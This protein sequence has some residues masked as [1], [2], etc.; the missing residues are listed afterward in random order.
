MNS[1]KHILVTVLISAVLSSCSGTFPDKKDCTPVGIFDE[2]WNTVNER[3]VCF[4]NKDIDW[5]AAYDEYRGRITGETDD[6]QLFSTLC[7]M[8]GE[9]KDGH[10]SL[11]DG[12]RTWS[13]HRPDSVGN[14]SHYVVF[15]YLGGAG[16]RMAGGLY[17]NKIKNGKIGLIRYDS[18]MDD[19]SYDDLDEAFEFC[20]DCYGIIFDIRS[21][22]GG[23]AEN[24]LKVI[25]YLPC[26]DAI[27]KTLVR[28]NDSHT[29]F[30]PSGTMYK[31]GIADRKKV[32]NKPFVVLIDNKSY[33]ASSLFAL[34]AMNCENVC[35]MGVK[36]AGG[37]S[38]PYKY[39]LSNGWIFS[40][41]SIKILSSDGMD[42]ECGV[43]PDIEIEL[44]WEQTKQN[45]D[46]IIDAACDYILVSR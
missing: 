32:W 19:I 40:L 41:P 4:P 12:H 14:V 39:E 6:S 45:K 29:D 27:Y 44:D 26:K 17:Y 43:P 25:D 33:S 22:Y 1:F 5:Y 13:G 7:Q 11:T 21:N 24:E 28:H 16:C 42:Y 2:L 38:I 37:T 20:K 30:I 18:F 8:L 36:T 34:S 10:V 31:P 9:L 3:Y 35:I 46:N 15:E 23:M